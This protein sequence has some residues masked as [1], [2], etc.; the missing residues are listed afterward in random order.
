MYSCKDYGFIYK[1]SMWLYSNMNSMSTSGYAV[2]VQNI[3]SNINVDMRN[4]FMLI[5]QYDDEKMCLQSFC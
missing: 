5:P 2:A 1:Q 4:E 3:M